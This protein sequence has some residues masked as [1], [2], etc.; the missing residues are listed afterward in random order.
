MKVCVFGAGA[1]GGQIA[2]RLIAAKA[3]DVCVVARGANLAAMRSRPLVFRSNDQEITAQVEQATD[4]PAS[5]PP[6]DLL[7]VTLKAPALPA[8]AGTLARL[9]APDGCALFVTNGI[10]WWWR[11]GL[12]GTPATLPLLDPE[13]ALWSQ[14][15]PRRVLGCVA[16]TPTEAV[17][18]G[19]I[20]HR[21]FN[22]WLLGEPDNRMSQRLRE[23]VAMFERAAFTVATSTDLRRDIW[24]KLVRNASNGTLSALIR[25]PLA[26]ACDDPDLQQVAAALIRETLDVAAALGWDVRSEVDIADLTR[27]S[28]SRG[29]PRSSTLQDVLLGR[30]LEIDALIGQTQAFAREKGVPVPTIDV[31]VPLLR[32]LDKSLALQRSGEV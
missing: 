11:Y 20:V 31:I 23:A 2:A 32:A 25:G 30:P 21:G 18:P 28:D 26:A 1:I 10:P 4:N 15:T 22:R 8:M 12:P 14:V 27:H 19:V 24:R 17:E 3:A 13:G 9:I 5:L 29:G 6:Q 16:Y 7:I